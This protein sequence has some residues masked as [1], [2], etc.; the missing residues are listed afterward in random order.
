[1]KKATLLFLSI[2]FFVSCSNSDDASQDS[3]PD[4]TLLRRVVFY[5]ENANAKQIWDFEERGLLATIST[6]NG[7]ILQ[8]FIYDTYYNLVSATYLGETYNFSYN[9][10]NRLT[11]VNGLAVFFDAASNR[12]VAELGTPDPTTED[13]V[14]HKREWQLNASGLLE[15]EVDYITWVM[16]DETDTRL[17]V[18]Y[19]ANENLKTVSD[20]DMA[21]AAFTHDSNTNP[22]RHATM[23]ITRAMGLLTQGWSSNARLKFISSLHNSANNILSEVHN[24]EDPESSKFEYIYNAN[25]L[26]QSSI[27]KSYYLGNFESQTQFAHYYYQGDTL[28]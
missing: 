25:G 10:Q 17:L 28:P 21:Y 1:M 3:Q 14:P 8:R 12:Y 9:A 27:S 20:L 24:P 16:G 13:P 19:D 4:P 2:L 7:A 6:P 22:L 5:P 23:P 18:T 11:S 15:T 26:P